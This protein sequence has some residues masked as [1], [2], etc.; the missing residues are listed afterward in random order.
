MLAA[1]GVPPGCP[2]GFLLRRLIIELP[3]V[4][5][6]AARSRSSAM[7]ERVEVLGLSLSVP[8]LWAAWNILAKATLGVAAS[9]LLAPPRSRGA[10]ARAERLRMPQLMVQIAMFM[11]RYLDVIVGEMRRM[12]VARESRGFRPRP[13]AGPVARRRPGRSS[14][15]RTSEANGCTW[16]C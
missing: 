11:L 13:A 4:A 6:A 10:A 2:P 8:G 15:A 5:F 1:R 7:G 12:R 3:F 16:P 9:I 14:S